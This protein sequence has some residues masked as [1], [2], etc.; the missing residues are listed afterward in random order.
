MCC[1]WDFGWTRMQQ[2]APSKTKA[3]SRRT[4]NKDSADHH[5]TRNAKYLSIRAR[6]Y[7]VVIR[8]QVST[9]PES[10]TLLD[11]TELLSICLESLQA[12]E[13]L[14]SMW[15]ALVPFGAMMGMRLHS[16]WIEHDHMHHVHDP[17][18]GLVPGRLV[19][20]CPKN[21]V[22]NRP[23]CLCVHICMY[24]HIKDAYIKHFSIA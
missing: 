10:S 13:I 2:S 22:C 18:L 21:P 15:Q 1:L 16:H 12:A 7:D 4:Q 3:I 9:D 6:K 14:Q 5:Y 11:A 17:D 19:L 24:A 20:I 8:S 23:W